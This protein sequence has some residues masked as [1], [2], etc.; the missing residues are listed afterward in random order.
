MT[1]ITEAL[2]EPMAGE[3]A[4]RIAMPSAELTC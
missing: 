2:D 1:V 3:K 4:I